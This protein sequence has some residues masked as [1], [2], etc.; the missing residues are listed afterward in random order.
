VAFVHTQ[1]RAARE[2]GAAVLLLSD[3]LDEILAL[4]DDLA[5]MHAGHLS[6]CKPTEGW[7]RAEIGLAMAGALEHAA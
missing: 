6:A 5:V 3:D 1:L 4:A 2:A 7:S